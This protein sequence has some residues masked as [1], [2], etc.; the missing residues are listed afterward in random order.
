MKQPGMEEI[1]A[2]RERIAVTKPSED[3][4]LGEEYRYVTA[5]LRR[6][7]II[8]VVMLAVLI[9]LALLLP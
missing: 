4:E 8:A 1:A 5:D 3:S 2:V 7:A 9:A 6:I